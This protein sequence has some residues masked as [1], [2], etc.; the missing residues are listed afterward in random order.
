VGRRPAPV[1]V[2]R[3][4]V[5]R[6]EHLRILLVE[7]SK[8]D[9][10]LALRELKRGGIVA[11]VSLVQNEAEFRR[12][13]EDARPHIILSDSTR[14]AFS[15]G[16]ARALARERAPDTPFIFVSRTMGEEQAVGA[17]KNGAADYVL[18]SNL[19]RFPARLHAPSRP[20]A[21]AP[22]GN[23]PNAR[24]ARTRASRARFSKH[25]SIASSPSTTRGR[26]SNSILRQ[27]R[28]SESGAPRHSAGRWPN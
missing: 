7:D 22:P 19:T 11:D 21:I 9:A 13:L 25:R 2:A 26:S 6:A 28:R 20:H 14:P 1:G 5:D 23:G 24:C 4:S 8:A 27:R 3:P 17:L 15:G 16:R 12:A 18:R 10:A